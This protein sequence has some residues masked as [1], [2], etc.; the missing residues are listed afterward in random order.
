MK[1]NSR[2]KTQRKRIRLKR[3]TRTILLV[4]KNWMLI[5]PFS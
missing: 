5:V 3:R 2:K 4:M 1:N